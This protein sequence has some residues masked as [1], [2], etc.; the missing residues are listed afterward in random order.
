MKNLKAIFLSAGFLLVLLT[1]QSV[2]MFV[3]AQQITA[4]TPFEQLAQGQQQQQQQQQQHRQEPYYLQHSQH[5]KRYLL[6]EQ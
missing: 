4:S 3:H 2:T 1:A 5:Q 6:M